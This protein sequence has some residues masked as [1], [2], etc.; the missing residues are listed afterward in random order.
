MIARAWRVRVRDSMSRVRRGVFVSG[1]EMM[2]RAGAEV[3]GVIAMGRDVAE[4]SRR[5]GCMMQ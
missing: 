4:S 2:M 5:V 1:A 3:L